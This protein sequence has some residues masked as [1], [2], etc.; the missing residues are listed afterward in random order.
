MA[1]VTYA[2][3]GP[4]VNNSAPGISAT[5]LNNVESFLDEI[6]SSIVNDTN[7]TTDGAGNMTGVSFKG[8]LTSKGG[9]HTL[10]DWNMGIT[11]GVTSAGSLVTHGLKNAAGV[12]TTPTA[13]FALPNFVAANQVVS[14]GSANTTQ[15]T[16]ATNTASPSINVWWI[17]ILM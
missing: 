1:F 10:T 7:Y 17:A 15:F 2:N 6:V 12:A 3:T 8:V 9:G 14:A 11:S 4:F 13:I 5:F 16:L